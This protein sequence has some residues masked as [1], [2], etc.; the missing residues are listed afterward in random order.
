MLGYGKLAVVEDLEE[1]KQGGREGN[2]DKRHVSQDG[3][4][5]GG[6][7]AYPNVEH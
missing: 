5:Q 4:K 7:M 6:E 1:G 3:Q 2:L